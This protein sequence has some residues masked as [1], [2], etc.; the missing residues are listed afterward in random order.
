MPGEEESAN[1]EEEGVQR[2]PTI[3]DFAP[4]VFTPQMPPPASTI[5]Y[6]TGAIGNEAHQLRRANIDGSDD[7]QVLGAE[8]GLVRPEG[9]VVDRTAG[10]VYIANMGR[11]GGILKMSVAT[12]QVQSLV[13]VDTYSG[14][15]PQGIE[16]LKTPG[17]S[18]VF[19]ADPDPDVHAVMT[20]DADTGEHLERLVQGTSHLADVSLDAVHER[21]YYADVLRNEVGVV[22]VDGSLPQAVV[23]N[24][25]QPTGVAVDG[26]SQY[27]FFATVAEAGGTIYRTSLQGL[28]LEII[29]TH[30]TQ[31]WGFLAVDP[32]TQTLFA[33]EVQGKIVRMGYDGQHMGVVVQG[34]ENSAFAGIGLM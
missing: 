7:V 25:M 1:T 29:Y 33:S 27:L 14:F 30:P 23:S 26:W 13:S 22:N 34:P 3:F 12:S 16:L 17:R 15:A 9:I 32:A 24:I 6:A 31:W 10:Q 5:F 4:P 20:A 11:T 2:A 18:T 21:L 28:D 8:D 19:W